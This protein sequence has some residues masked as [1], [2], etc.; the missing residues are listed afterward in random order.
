MTIEQSPLK[1]HRKPNFTPVFLSLG[2][3]EYS[4]DISSIGKKYHA[5]HLPR[6][7]LVSELFI[8][9]LWNII[10]KDEGFVLPETKLIQNNQLSTDQSLHDLFKKLVIDFFAHNI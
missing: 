3:N 10:S 6:I 9:S 5:K 2:H 7:C 8:S 1:I 4:Y